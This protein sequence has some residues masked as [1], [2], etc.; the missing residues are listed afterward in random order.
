MSMTPGCPFVVGGARLEAAVQDADQPVGEL[1]QGG[2][3]ADFA[4]A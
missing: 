2:E 3:V 1:S 4:G